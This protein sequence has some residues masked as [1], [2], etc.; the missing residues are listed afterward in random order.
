MRFLRRWINKVRGARPLF[1]RSIAA[2]RS[3][4]LAGTFEDSGGA[5]PLGRS[6]RRELEYRL[7]LP[8]GSSPSDS[9]PLIVMLH[10]CKQDPVG[11]AEGT[12]M[13]ALADDGRCAV[14]YPA[15]SARSNPLRCWNWFEPDSL[16]GRGEAALIARLIAQITRR[17]PID[18]R[19]VY[20]VGMSADGAMACVL[21]VCHSRLIAACAIH[22]G[23]PYGAARSAAQ[24][25]AAMRSGTPPAS[26]QQDR[27]PAREAGESNL[28]VPTLVIHGDRDA[29]VNP[30]NADQIIELLAMRAESI[31][32]TA[33]VVR[34]GERRVESGGRIYRQQDYLQGGRM[35]LR[36]VMVEGLG[37]A[38]SGGDPRHEFNDAHGPDASRLILDFVLRYELAAAPAIPT[39]LKWCALRPI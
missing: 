31:H 9:L 16:A 15:Q 28:M 30:I 7:Y 2:G 19:R 4:F 38:W 36:K 18:P 29:T 17:R 37:H 11:F 39:S 12:R 24:A 33:G 32:P 14:L 26:P 6:P 10:G 25:L 5:A 13:N 3:R 27:Q 20:V 23:V 22:S 35:V 8:S 1:G 21:A 34:D